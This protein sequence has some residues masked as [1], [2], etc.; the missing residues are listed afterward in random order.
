[1]L[2][3]KGLKSMWRQA[4]PILRT[5]LQGVLQRIIMQ[6]GSPLRVSCPS[7][8]L[9]GPTCA[10]HMWQ[11]SVVALDSVCLGA[12]GRPGSGRVRGEGGAAAAG[13]ALRTLRDG[14]DGGFVADHRC[15]STRHTP[16]PA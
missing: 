8:L 14:H 7:F 12:G 9:L 6:A 4:A 2:M 1:M 11:H 16:C 13:G 15:A 3:V 5:T 10:A